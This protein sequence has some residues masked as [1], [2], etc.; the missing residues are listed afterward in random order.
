M[1]GD[2]HTVQCAARVDQTPLH[3]SLCILVLGFARWFYQPFPDRHFVQSAE[4]F[5]H[6]AAGTTVHIAINPVPWS[7]TLIK[8]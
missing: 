7:M 1:V 2:L 4:Q 5:E 3:A 8:H 6:T